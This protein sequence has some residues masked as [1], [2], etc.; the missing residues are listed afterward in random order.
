VVQ[1]S[2][3]NADRTSTARIQASVRDARD[4]RE[5]LVAFRY[6]LVDQLLGDTIG[7]LFEKLLRDF[8]CAACVPVQRQHFEVVEGIIA[9]GLKGLWQ[10]STL[11]EN[12]SLGSIIPA[13]YVRPR[14]A[15]EQ[16]LYRSAAE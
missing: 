14:V 12:A 10:V 8:V 4:K 2:T 1:N 11:P 15:A 7:C 3:R 5:N 9:D 16:Q 13:H 6:R